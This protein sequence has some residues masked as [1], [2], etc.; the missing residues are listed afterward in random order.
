LE[1]EERALGD[2]VTDELVEEGGGLLF[3]LKID[4]ARR[5]RR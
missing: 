4:T 1:Q 5:R 2:E 3:E